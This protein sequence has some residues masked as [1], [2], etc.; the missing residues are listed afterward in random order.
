MHTVVMILKTEDGDDVE[1]DER[2][3][4]LVHVSAG[5]S[6]TLCTGEVFEFGEGNASAKTKQVSRGGITCEDCLDIINEI[7]SIRL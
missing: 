4:C 2:K 3:W 5:A 7:K 6:M 1:K